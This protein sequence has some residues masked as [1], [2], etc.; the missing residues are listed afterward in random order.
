MQI[1]VLEALRASGSANPLQGL[2]DE[3]GLRTGDEVDS[4]QLALQMRRE[5]SVRQ[6][7]L[8]PSACS[9]WT[10]AMPCSNEQH[11]DT[12][13]DGIRETAVTR[14]ERLIDGRFDDFPVAGSDLVLLDGPVQTGQL[15]LLQRLER[16]VG[17]GTAND[18]EQ[19]RING[20]QRASVGEFVQSLAPDHNPTFPR[21]GTG[22]GAWP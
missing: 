19:R 4:G 6:L 11:R 2:A 7:Q 10:S 18:V 20:H 17:H 12:V 1:A 13:A 9:S 16:L 8:R 3:Q 22:R 21:G 5:S 14:R 15:A